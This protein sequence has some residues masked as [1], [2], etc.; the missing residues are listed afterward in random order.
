VVSV[1]PKPNETKIS[2]QLFNTTSRE[3][4]A[5]FE[6]IPVGI[7]TVAADFGLF[8]EQRS[9]EVR[10]NEESRLEIKRQVGSLDLNSKPANAKYLITKSEGDAIRLDGDTP[11]RFDN[12]PAGP[13]MVRVW[14]GDYVQERR[15]TIGS[16][17]TNRL[18]VEFAYAEV[19][20]ETEPAGAQVVSGGRPL[21]ETPLTLSELIPGPLKVNIER[22]GYVPLALTVN[23]V[24]NWQVTIKTNLMNVNYGPAMERARRYARGPARD[25]QKAL[26]SVNEALQAMP[27]DSEGTELKAKLESDLKESQAKLAEKQRE[28]DL[29]SAQQRRVTQ[30]EARQRFPE[31]TFRK[32]TEQVKDAD[33]FDAHSWTAH[34]ESAYVAAA[35]RRMIERPR[36][37]WKLDDEN[38][39]NDETFLFRCTATKGVLSTTRQNAVIV[40]GQVEKGE[41]Q[42]YAKFWDYVATERK[43]SLSEGLKNEGMVPVN[44][45]FLP[46]QQASI[47]ESRRKSVPEDFKNK[48]FNELNL[49]K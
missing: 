18:D 30:E 46:P 33:F 28:Q 47:V 43:L 41:A 40:V 7:Y 1:A 23:A 2:G 6:L 38:K 25:Y 32:A 15:T 37:G 9:V 35:L 12:L 20:L 34:S 29:I 44:V 24:A 16:G 10:R 17:E 5:K 3:A 8:K 4:E 39:V 49:P 42:I 19:R 48:L 26:L 36:S 31:T 14:R 21:G 22:R 45:R 11:A 13:Y 27:G